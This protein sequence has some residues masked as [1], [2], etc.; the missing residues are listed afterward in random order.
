M[1]KHNKIECF[2]T[3]LAR[4]D[5]CSIFRSF[6]TRKWNYIVDKFEITLI[7]LVC[8]KLTCNFR[9]ILMYYLALIW[10][11]S[12]TYLLPR[13]ILLFP[14]TKQLWDPLLRILDRFEQWISGR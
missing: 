2:Y 5:I 7:G 6:K 8:I 11:Q 9:S 4:I 1:N 10:K 13:N 12:K 3:A 14:G